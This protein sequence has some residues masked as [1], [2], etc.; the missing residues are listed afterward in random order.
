[1]KIYKLSLL[2]SFVTFIFFSATIKAEMKKSEINMQHIEFDD[3]KLIK[4]GEDNIFSMKVCNKYTENY[5]L[6]KTFIPKPNA[7]AIWG[8]KIFQEGKNIKYKGMYIKY[9][10]SIFPLGYAII[11]PSKCLSMSVKLNKYFDYNQSKEIKLK[12]NIGFRCPTLSKPY[13]RFGTEAILLAK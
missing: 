11:E 13:K 4:S 10:M 8:F 9:K 3:I 1:M 5:Y 12:Y 6:Y 7:R 2:V